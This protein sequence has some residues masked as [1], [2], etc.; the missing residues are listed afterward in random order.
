MELSG[1]GQSGW[2]TDKGNQVTRDTKCHWV[3]LRRIQ[4]PMEGDDQWKQQPAPAFLAGKACLFFCFGKCPLKRGRSSDGDSP[5]YRS[6]HSG[7]GGLSAVLSRRR[8]TVC[9]R[10]RAWWSIQEV[11]LGAAWR[12]M[13]GRRRLVTQQESPSSFWGFSGPAHPQ[14]VAPWDCSWKCWKVVLPVKHKTMDRKEACNEWMIAAG[15]CL[16]RVYL[17]VKSAY[18]GWICFGNKR[19]HLI[20]WAMWI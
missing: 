6:G 2:G 4:R 19:G 8:Q 12:R 15:N 9:C 17:N 11:S 1:S 10:E 3:S 7:R 18:S 20:H 13:G 5:R 16:D 14:T